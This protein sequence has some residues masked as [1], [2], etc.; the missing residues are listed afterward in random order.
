MASSTLANDPL[1]KPARLYLMRHG[2]VKGHDEK[3]LYG[4]N[5]VELTEEGIDQFHRL[6][7]RVKREGITAIYS[8]DLRR[9]QEGAKIIARYLNIVPTPPVRELREKSFG[10]FEGLTFNE[11]AERFAAEQDEAM[12]GW[13]SSCPPGAESL[14]DFSRRVI[15]SLDAILEK[16]AGERIALVGHGGVNRVILLHALGLELENFFCFEQD[17]GCL[18]I[19]DYHPR[20]A[21]IRLV[22]GL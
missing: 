2:Q 6:G 1:V 14:R 13:I 22:N 19:L 20:G 21:V 17:Y 7:E 3:R 5:E 16:H 8:S 18:N 9:S 10:I 11:I 15:R 12:S 4:H